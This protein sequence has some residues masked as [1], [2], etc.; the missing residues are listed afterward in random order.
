MRDGRQKSL[1]DSLAEGEGEARRAAQ[2]GTETRAAKPE[3]ESPATTSQL[4]EVI[5]SGD[6]MRKAYRRV[7]AN[8]GA[9]GVDGMTVAQ[10]GPHLVE[11]WPRY[12]EQLLAGVYKPQPVRQVLIPKPD[13]GQRMLGVPTVVDRLIQ[14]AVLQVL[15]PEWDATFS[16]HSYGFRPGRS[17]HQAVAAAQRIIAEGH[18]WVVD[19]DLEK[20]FDR[21]NHDVLMSR[22]A[23]RVS[24][25]RVLKL[26]RGFL[27]AGILAH[28]LV[29]PREE[30]T[31]QGGPLSP[32]LSNLLLDE[33]DKELEARGHRFVRY[34]DDCNLYVRSERAGQRVLASVT[35]WL[36]RRLRLKVNAAKSGVARP[37]AS[38]FLGFSF[39]GG[40]EPKRRVAP[41][42]LKRFKQRVRELT[43]R[44]RGVALAQMVAELRKY[45]VGWR[46]YYGFCQWTS[47]LRE[48]DRWIRRKLR[49]LLWKQWKQGRTRFK[50]LQA[51]GVGHVL[52]ARTAGSAKSL[53][54]VSASP[55]LSYALPNA[56]FDALGLPRLAPSS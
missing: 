31:P 22:V 21:V 49:C 36:S 14:Q 32:L 34:A 9:P 23:R 13:G 41:Q 1:W 12:R 37:S 8:K 26:I 20:F 28:G 24:D 47:V 39:T 50:E 19:L 40:K 55:A 2:R 6:N 38:K 30:G 53:W 56:F 43:R 45:L 11:H 54:R 25:K 10:L 46:G 16:E 52:A 35:A 4:M 29:S 17:A 7:R 5:V 48:L 3:T 44:G 33:W 15:Q 27:T 51:R 18:G 42:A